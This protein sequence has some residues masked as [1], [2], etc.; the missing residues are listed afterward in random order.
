MWITKKNR[1]LI[2]FLHENI[3]PKYNNFGVS[4]GLKHVD[5]VV[6]CAEWYFNELRRILGDCSDLNMDINVLLVAAYYHDVGLEQGRKGHELRSAE[7]LRSDTDKLLVYLKDPWKVMQATDAV[8]DHRSSSDVPC[9]SLYGRLLR[10]ADTECSAK[11]VLIRCINSKT[12]QGISPTVEDLY[13]DVS[14]KFGP[15]GY[16]WRNLQLQLPS[17]LQVRNDCKKHFKDINTFTKLW[18]SLNL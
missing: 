6:F 7:F 16:K 8:E 15:N 14:N 12:E 13:E 18:E 17:F 10:C 2:C 4:H 1:E 5:S 9:R 11:N 3:R